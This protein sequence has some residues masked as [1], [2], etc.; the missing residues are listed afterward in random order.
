MDLST[1]ADDFAVL[2]EGEHVHRHDGLQPE[3]DYE[4]D[5]IAVRTLPRPGGELLCVFATVNDVHFG[6]I[7]AGRIDDSPLGPVQRVEPGESPP[8]P[9]R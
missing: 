6:E 2:H 5:G 7:D 8:T 4:L 1:V 9:R 3:T